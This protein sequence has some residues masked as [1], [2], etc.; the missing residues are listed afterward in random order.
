MTW[1]TVSPGKFLRIVKI[2]VVL[3]LVL[4]LHMTR[5]RSPVQQNLNKLPSGGADTEAHGSVTCN[6]ELGK[7]PEF[8]FFLIQDLGLPGGT[9]G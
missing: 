5:I 1:L 8:F 9:V 6:S 3:K 4:N 7:L 2:E